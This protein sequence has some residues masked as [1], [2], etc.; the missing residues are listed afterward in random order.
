M[1]LSSIVL[2]YVGACAGEILFLDTR[3]VSAFPNGVMSQCVIKFPL[4]VNASPRIPDFDR[5]A[6]GAYGVE[7]LFILGMIAAV[8]AMAAGLPRVASWVDR[9][10]LAR[11]VLIPDFPNVT[12]RFESL[13]NEARLAAWRRPELLVAMTMVHQPFTIDLPRGRPLVVIPPK[14]AVLCNDPG[15]FDPVIL[16][17]LAHVRARDVSL[18]SAVRG[19]AWV[20]IPV[21]AL[22]C[23]P[24][25]LAVGGT[26]VSRA[27]LIET[28]IRTVV[29]VA[30]TLVV[31]ARSIRRSEIAADRQVVRWQGSSEPL[32]RLLEVGG[33]SVRVKPSNTVRRWLRPLARYP[34]FVT[35]IVALRDPTYMPNVGPGGPSEPVTP[36]PAAG[37]PSEPVTP[38]PAAGGPSEPVTPVPAA[39]GPSEPVITVSLVND[40]TKLASMLESGVLT[41][42][43]FDHLKARLL[44]T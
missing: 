39:G 32:I 11:A 43:E 14:L 2:G 16:H 17:E 21:M 19:T 34:S 25:F 33:L 4:V 42:E 9:R 41:R 36:V 20:T 13:C 22:A 6:V 15:R 26:Q 30:A 3:A 28:L 31:G 29:I 24:G 10:R 12:A 18:V 27:V 1:R 44:A 5:C 23:V 8:L 7:G 37:G 35:R 40:L 38:V